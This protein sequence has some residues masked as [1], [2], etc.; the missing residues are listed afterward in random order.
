[1]NQISHGEAPTDL[2]VSRGDGMGVH[3][4]HY[5]CNIAKEGNKTGHAHDAVSRAAFGHGCWHACC[6]EPR[7]ILLSTL[8]LLIIQP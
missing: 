7:D 4:M 6:G 1:M 3:P 8:S 2:P 5:F